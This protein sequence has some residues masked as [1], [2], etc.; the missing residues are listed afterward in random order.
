MNMKD[1][2]SRIYDQ[3]LGYTTAPKLACKIGA[4]EQRSSKAVMRSEWWNYRNELVI[5]SLIIN[6]IVSI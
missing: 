5:C 1:N 3:A 4:G 2:Q 6:V